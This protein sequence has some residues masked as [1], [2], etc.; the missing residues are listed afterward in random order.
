[1]GVYYT[2]SARQKNIDTVHIFYEALRNQDMEA[3]NA[4]LTDDVELYIVGRTPVSGR[5]V[6]KDHGMVELATKVFSLI[7][8][9]TWNFGRNYK[10]V[11]ADDA[12][13]VAMFEG[14]GKSIHGHDY[15]QTYMELF[16][17]RDQKISNIY[18]M[19]DTA[20]IETSLFD[21]PLSIP[22]SDPVL[23]L[24]MSKIA[25]ENSAET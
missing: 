18:E 17:F 7:E 1:L 21:N 20:M 6:G 16:N 9:G 10:I 13:V 25:G 15:T 14:G 5:W 4:V 24:N 2:M 12:A 11:C 8:P 23:P 22:E 3:A 19:I